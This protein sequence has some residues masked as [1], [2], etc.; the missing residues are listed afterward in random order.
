[1]FIEIARSTILK[2]IILFLRFAADCRGAS[3]TIISNL[4]AEWKETACFILFCIKQEQHRDETCVRGLTSILKTAENAFCRLEGLPENEP[5]AAESRRI[6]ISFVRSQDA[7]HDN[8]CVQLRVTVS[9]RGR[10][11]CRHSEQMS[12]YVLCVRF[13]FVPQ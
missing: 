4:C 11:S 8:S 1:M 3:G 6:S 10:G 5:V 7:T 9:L 12:Q 13:S 2:S